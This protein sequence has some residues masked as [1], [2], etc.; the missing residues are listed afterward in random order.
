MTQDEQKLA[1]API[2]QGE[3]KHAVQ[4][5][6]KTLAILFQSPEQHFGVAA[7]T[8]CQAVFSQLVPQLTVVIDFP[9]EDDEDAPIFVKDGLLA[10]SKVN[11]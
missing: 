6:H 5:R 2:P 3:R 11:N 1:V 4:T 7:G 10:T 9:I 8:E